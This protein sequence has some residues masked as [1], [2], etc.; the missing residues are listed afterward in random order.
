MKILNTP[1]NPKWKKFTRKE[2]KENPQVFKPLFG[3]PYALHTTHGKIIDGYR[4]SLTI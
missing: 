1:R 2:V 3:K 4:E